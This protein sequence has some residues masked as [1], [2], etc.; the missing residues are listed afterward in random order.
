MKTEERGRGGR[1]EV[2]IMA[3]GGEKG[4]RE[5]KVR[6][7]SRQG[8]REDGDDNDTAGR[9]GEER[10]ARQKGMRACFSEG[11]WRREGSGNRGERK[12][13]GR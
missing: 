1:G 10:E 2:M 13:T 11:G 12:E 8:R 5:G 4:E 9:D 3:G 6:R 7:E